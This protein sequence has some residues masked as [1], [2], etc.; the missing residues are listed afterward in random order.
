MQDGTSSGALCTHHLSV[1]VGFASEIE[2]QN[3]PL[4]LLGKLTCSETEALHC[5]GCLEVLSVLGLYL[6]GQATSAGDTSRHG[7]HV[8]GFLQTEIVST[9]SMRLKFDIHP[10]EASNSC[11]CVALLLFI[12]LSMNR[13]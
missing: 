6:G 12:I 8:G 2:T 1:N 10:P 3:P 9:G 5:F 11:H 4:S 7:T 13:M